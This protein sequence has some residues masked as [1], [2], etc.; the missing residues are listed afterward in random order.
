M[1]C[2]RHESSE[3]LFFVMPGGK[4]MPVDAIT[5][6]KVVNDICHSARTPL[7]GDWQGFTVCSERM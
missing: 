5:R 2:R 6:I 7:G 1:S 3:M 4:S